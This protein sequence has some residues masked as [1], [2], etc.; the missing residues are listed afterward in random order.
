MYVPL[1][2]GE[3]KTQISLYN[4]NQ[5]EISYEIKMISDPEE[6]VIRKLMPG[7]GVHEPIPILVNNPLNKVVIAQ[8][9]KVS[10]NK[11]EIPLE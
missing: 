5:P 3:Q 1:F 7:I 9:T 10:L 2:I 11:K 6:I 8:L 4:P